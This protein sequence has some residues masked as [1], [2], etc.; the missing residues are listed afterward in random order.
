MNVTIAADVGGE[1]RVFLVPRHEGGY[2]KVGTV[3]E[4]VESIRLP[5]GARGV[6]LIGLHRGIA[7][8]AHTDPEGNLRVE[9][10]E[11]PDE[12]PPGI[13]TREVEREYRAT[14]EE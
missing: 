10:E 5:G 6:S 9:V 2:A 8:A 12:E 7:G 13:Q 3:A 11:R 4:V 1:E 14:V